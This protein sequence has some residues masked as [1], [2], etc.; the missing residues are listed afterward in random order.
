MPARRRVLA[1]ER[2]AGGIPRVRNL[3]WCLLRTQR[4]P[5]RDVR[6]RV[7]GQRLGVQAGEHRAL[8]SEP[9]ERAGVQARGE[10]PGRG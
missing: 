8:R 5:A 7:L 9:R 4:G 6:V 10:A 2:A 3:P 1:G